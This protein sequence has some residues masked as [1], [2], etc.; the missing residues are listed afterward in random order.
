MFGYIKPYK[1]EMR[2]KE[3]EL[4]RSFYCSMCKKLGKSYGVLARFT[5]NYEFVF[6]SLLYASLNDGD[7]PTVQK[8]CPFNPAKKCNY[9]KNM[10]EEFEFS[11]SAAVMLLYYK[12]LDNLRDEKGIKR[13][14]YLALKP[15]FKTNYNKARVKYPQLDRLFSEYDAAQQAV[16]K[17]GITDIDAA[18]EPSAKMLGGLFEMCSDDD[19]QK[20][21]L[22]RLGYCMGRYVYIIDAAADLERD[23]KSGAYNPIKDREDA[24]QLCERQLYFSVNEASAA[25]ELLKICKFKNIIGNIITLGLEDTFK[26]ELTK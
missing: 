4:Y 18:A 17:L 12:L 7:C 16:E 24:L 26:K 1:P 5:L 19:T 6:L 15:V 11:S 20:R 8:R 10:G 2:M 23:K 13:L 22:E 3:Y 21:V 9:C 14:G 25:F